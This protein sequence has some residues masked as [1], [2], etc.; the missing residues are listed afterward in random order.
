MVRYAI[1]PSTVI[2][3][4]R[5]TTEVELSTAKLDSVNSL[6]IVDLGVSAMITVEKR[7]H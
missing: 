7:L 1:K 6:V 4:V 5:M 3:K 2:I